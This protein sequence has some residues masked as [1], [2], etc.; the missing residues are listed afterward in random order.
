MSAANPIF[1]HQMSTV[2]F[3]SPLENFS[4]FNNGWPI[5]MRETDFDLAK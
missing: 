4:S 3:I 2:I 1:I 5:S